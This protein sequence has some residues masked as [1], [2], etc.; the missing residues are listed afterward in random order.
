[1]LER[2][3]IA[4]CFEMCIKQ[5]QALFWQKVEFLISKLVVHKVTTKLSGAGGDN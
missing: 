1:M 4:V 2:E 3:I 5:I